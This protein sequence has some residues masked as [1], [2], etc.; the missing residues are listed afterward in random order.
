MSVAEYGRLPFI[1]ARTLR[2]HFVHEPTDNRFRAAARMRQALW[3]QQH[4]W[5]PGYQKSP[6]GTRRKIG[7]C[8]E[9][10]AARNGANFISADVA[11]LVRRE[12]A[13]RE[14]GALI[15]EG[16]LATNLLSSAP[17]VFNT[18]GP[19][20]LD[21]KLATR[22]FRRLFPGFVQTVTGILF[23]HAPDR[24]NPTYTA[25]FTAF[26]LLVQ[27][28]T[29][30]GQRGFIAI[31]VKYTETLTEPAARLRPRYDELSA[32]S[33]C[34]KAPENPILRTAPLQQFWRQ[35]M[36]AAAIVQ[37]GLY[38][39]GR[40]AVVAP[41][42]NNLVQDAV[43]IFREQIAETAPVA[44]DAMSLESVVETIG[45]AGAHDIAAALH[46]RYCD[47][48]TIADLI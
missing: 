25:D 27:C 28:R 21:L 42:F 45:N 48:T 20:K 40:F 46:D 6:D 9:T 8:V 23:E 13:F 18:F 19:L 29:I 32:S 44:F 36:L 1:P 3:R 30:G 16:R 26:D 17:V 24:G 33:G 47:F 15:D 39:V 43:A 14:D 38:A 22:V 4:G 12:I 41:Q 31:E 10:A 5:K 11:Q 34:F 35:E 7:N 37:N 2:K